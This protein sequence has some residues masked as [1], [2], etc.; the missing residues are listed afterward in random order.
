M[1]KFKQQLI[2]ITSTARSPHLWLFFTNRN[3]LFEIRHFVIRLSNKFFVVLIFKLQM[4]LTIRN[5]KFHFWPVTLSWCLFLAKVF[6]IVCFVN[7]DLVYHF[8]T[9]HLSTVQV[10]SERKLRNDKLLFFAVLSIQ[11]SSQIYVPFVMAHAN[12][13]S[14][15]QL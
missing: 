10:C 14:N 3:N 11:K 4:N 5:F 8:A 9:C 13:L 1:N 2:W 7:L 6:G 15:K 12:Q